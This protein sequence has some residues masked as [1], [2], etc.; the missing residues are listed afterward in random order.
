M[1]LK[2]LFDNGWSLYN[3][4]LFLITTQD[5]KKLQNLC[6]C[7][8]QQ[9]QFVGHLPFKLWQSMALILHIFKILVHKY[10]FIII[11]LK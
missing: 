11:L 5:E 8:G 9:Q 4:F 7:F 3:V 2:N 10:S 1:N 6:Q